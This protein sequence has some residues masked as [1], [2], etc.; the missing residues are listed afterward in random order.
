MQRACS[1]VIL[2]VM[3]KKDDDI[4]RARQAVEGKKGGIK[5]LEKYGSSHFSKIAREMWANRRKNNARKGN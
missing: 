4:F 3:G 1:N 2:G 5:T